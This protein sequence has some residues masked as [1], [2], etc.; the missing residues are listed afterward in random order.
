M[1]DRPMQETG[2]M[3]RDWKYSLVDKDVAGG[4]VNTVTANYRDFYNYIHSEFSR[5]YK[6]LNNQIRH[7]FLK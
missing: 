3:E 7:L 4:K 5:R 1:A 2:D 6:K